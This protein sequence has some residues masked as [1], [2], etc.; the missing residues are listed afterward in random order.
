MVE[1]DSQESKHTLT[2]WRES[3]IYSW[4]W[5]KIFPIQLAYLQAPW[6]TCRSETMHTDVLYIHTCMY[7]ITSPDSTI[8]WPSARSYKWRGIFDREWDAQANGAL[9]HFQCQFSLEENATH[10]HHAEARPAVHTHRDAKKRQLLTHILKGVVYNSNPIHF[11]SSSEN[12]SS[13]SASFPFCVCAEK[14]VWCSYT[15]LAL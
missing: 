8:A 4:G 9:A 12:I 3:L 6:N 2:H 5:K 13:R 10:T 15:A 11:L 14:K 1:Y 7:T